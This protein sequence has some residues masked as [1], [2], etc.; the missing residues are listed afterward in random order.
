MPDSNSKRKSDL[1]EEQIDSLREK[2]KQVLSSLIGSLGSLIS[3]LD[4]VYPSHVDTEVDGYIEDILIKAVEIQKALDLK[5]K[6]LGL[7]D[8]PSLVSIESDS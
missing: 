5:R 6:L 3:D 8:Q 4:W 2:D 1:R 7:L